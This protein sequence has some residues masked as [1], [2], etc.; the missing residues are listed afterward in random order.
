MAAPKG[1]IPY[2]GCEKGGDFG[3]PPLL[4]GAASNGDREN[5]VLENLKNLKSLRGN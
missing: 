2:T 4:N 5:R 1:H 3:G